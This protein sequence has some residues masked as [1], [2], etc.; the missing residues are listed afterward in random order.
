MR[1]T[2]DDTWIAVAEV[3]ARRSLC[4][5]SQ[6]GAVIKDPHNRIVATGYNGPPSL[7]KRTERIGGDEPTCEHWCERG[8]NGPTPG[9]AITYLDCVSLHAEAN[10]LSVCDRS[11]REG[12][13]IY[14]T[15]DVCWSCAKLI[16]NS[17]LVRV[18]VS[19]PNLSP[20]RMPDETY[21][22]LRDCEIQVMLCRDNMTRR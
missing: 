6:V 17:G 21:K 8:R 7:F 11:I 4:V 5:R 16:A 2:W 10:A 13:T 15:S 1:Q 19:A 3:I 9:T 14:V 20:H 22:F 18:V 12:G